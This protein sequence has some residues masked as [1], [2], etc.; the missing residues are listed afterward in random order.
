MLCYVVLVLSAVTKHISNFE[1]NTRKRELK[2]VKGLKQQSSERRPW[3]ALKFLRGF[4][5][6]KIGSHKKI[7]GKSDEPSGLPSSSTDDDVIAKV[8]DLVTAYRGLTI[9]DAAEEQKVSLSTHVKKM[10]TT[11]FGIRRVPTD[12]AAKGAPLAC[13]R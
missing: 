6:S 12:T 7:C 5:A 11:D 9:R 10:F 3:A 1:Q 13:S 4:T 2:L 8:Q